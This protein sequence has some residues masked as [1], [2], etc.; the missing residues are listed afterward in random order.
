MKRRPLL[1]LLVLLVVGGG[2]FVWKS[3]RDAKTETF[4]MLDG[5]QITFQAVTVGTNQSYCFGNIFQ[6]LAARIPGRLGDILNGGT[7]YRFPT[8]SPNDVIFWF[9]HREDSSRT[10]FNLIPP[11]SGAS[12]MMYYR[13]KLKDD[14]GN[15][16]R[17]ST[18]RSVGQFP[19]GDFALFVLS[20]NVPTS[21]RTVRVRL[22]AWHGPSDWRESGEF[23]APN[24]LYRK[25]P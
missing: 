10:N 17:G 25:Q 13:I 21:S 8:D 24:P 20:T 2:L 7:V 18:C 3:S 23:T 1:I 6:R 19:S 11:T 4:V 12:S 14:Q 9:R 15:E 22:E 16:L 5:T